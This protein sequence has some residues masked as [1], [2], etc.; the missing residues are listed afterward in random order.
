MAKTYKIDKKKALRQALK[1][2]AKLKFPKRY[3]RAGKGETLDFSATFRVGGKHD[4]C[5][6]SRSRIIQAVVGSL[7][8]S[9][10]STVDDIIIDLNL[11][12]PKQIWDE[13]EILSAM[14]LS[15]IEDPYSHIDYVLKQSQFYAMPIG[16][17]IG[18]HKRRS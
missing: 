4:A 1:Q 16:T 14:E 5:G 2:L 13:E 8:S 17:A 11:N 9:G 18:R 15:G 6:A 10:I 3:F 12:L 7:I